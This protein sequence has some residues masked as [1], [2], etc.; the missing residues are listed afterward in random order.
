GPLGRVLH[1]TPR[2]LEIAERWFDRW[3]A[4]AIIFGR[5]VF[6][7][8]I[9][10]TVAAGIFRM[11]Y[12]VFA[13][14]VAVSTA[15]CA[16]AWLAPGIVFGNRIGPLFADHPWTFGLTLITGIVLAVLAA[17]QAWRERWE[18]WQ[19]RERRADRA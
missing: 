10:V 12:R 15:V 2:R 9:P 11:P 1:V 16:A 17:A 14:S 13:P 3:G 5:H 18:R 19:G 7:M 6:G 4:L 8:R